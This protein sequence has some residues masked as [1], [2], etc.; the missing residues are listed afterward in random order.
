MA[1]FDGVNTSTWAL[2]S[3]VPKLLHSQTAGRKSHRYITHL[4]D[5]GYVK[6]GHILHKKTKNIKIKVS[7]SRNTPSQ[8]GSTNIRGWIILKHPTKVQNSNHKRNIILKLFPFSFS[9]QNMFHFREICYNPY[10][11][12]P[13]ILYL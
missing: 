1:E 8:S 10:I 5:F 11:H 12:S 4:Y 9:H 3:T 2:S 13:S 7:T 6:V